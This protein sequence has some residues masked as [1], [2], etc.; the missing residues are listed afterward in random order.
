MDQQLRAV[1][2]VKIHSSIGIARL[3]NSQGEFFIGPERPGDRTPPEGGYK[4]AEGRVK[5][6]AARFRI[7][8]YDEQ[9]RLVREITNDDATI[10]WT[11]H[12]ANKK[13]SWRKFDGLNPNAPLRNISVTDRK[14][15]I[16]DPGPRT[17]SGVGSSAKFDTGKFF[18]KV[19]PLGEI[20]TDEAGRLLVLGGF[21]D[22]S[23]PTNTPLPTFAN[24]DGWHDDVSDGPVNATVTLNGSMQTMQAAGAWGIVAPP[25]FAPP[26][27]NITT[28]YDVLFEVA[29]KKF[30]LKLPSQPSFTRD[31]YPI[32]RGAMK[33]GWV[34]EMAS[35]NHH[36]IS[37]VI[38]PPGADAARAA[39]FSQLRNP[40]DGSGGD[41]PMLY[42]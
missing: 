39:I 2:T 31:I 30:G 11:V 23:S 37:S 35:Q 9:G 10:S 36:T 20:R 14:K 42:S 3:G 41:M 34:N 26:I 16:I 19:V 6:Q 4:D 29:V 21:G 1:R 7:F 8:G 5:R 27:E 32:L 25:D 13:A 38:P 18:N 15:L 40:N 28:L 22:S 24:N 12:L 33:M 17:I